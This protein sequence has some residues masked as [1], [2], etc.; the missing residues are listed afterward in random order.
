MA[1]VR[2]R[3]R[4]RLAALDM[5][6][7]LLNSLHETTPRTRDTIRRVAQAGGVLALGTG[8]CMSEIRSHLAQMP[9]IRYVICENGACVYDVA[10]DRPLA[11]MVLPDADAARIFDLIDRS[12]VLCQCFIGNQ[13]YMQIDRLE[14]LRYYLIEDFEPVFRQGTLFIPDARAVWRARGSVEKFDLY[15]H[16]AA[17]RDAFLSQI[18]DMQLQ[19]AG[20]LGVGIEISPPGATKASGLVELGRLLGIPIE[21]TMAIGDGGNDLEMMAAAGWAVAMGNAIDEVLA[22]ADARTEDCDHDGAARALERYMACA[23][24]SD[25]ESDGI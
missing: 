13:S 2:G 18:G 3:A 19:I 10:A 5:D 7:T 17:A 9:G 22:L 12:D 4:V 23:P 8:R 11:Q 25:G 6:G 1:E 15:F 21:E 16:T 24:A 14:R 20:S